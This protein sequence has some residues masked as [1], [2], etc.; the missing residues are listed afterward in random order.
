MKA[1]SIFMLLLMLAFLSAC[2]TEQR[3][4]TA[5]SWQRNRCNQL[6]DKAE[7]DRCASNGNMPYD[8]YKAQSEQPAKP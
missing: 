5:Q 7:V 3:Y 8:A 2:T 1:G 4:N 6:P